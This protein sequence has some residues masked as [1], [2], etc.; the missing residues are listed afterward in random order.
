MPDECIE[1]DGV[2]ALLIAELAQE[3]F[4]GLPVSRDLREVALDEG[5][6]DGRL[7]ALAGARPI[8]LNEHREQKCRQDQECKQRGRN[9]PDRD[10]LDYFEQSAGFWA[11]GGTS[12]SGVG[13]RDSAV[14]DRTVIL[15]GIGDYIRNAYPPDSRSAQ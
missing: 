14:I 15:S 2:G 10:D 6:D 12:P 11:H 9:D 7:E 5:Q 1:L 4:A 3:V 8:V 13:R